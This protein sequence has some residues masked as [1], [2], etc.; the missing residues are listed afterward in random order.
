MKTILNN[1]VFFG[2]ETEAMVL[3][4]TEEGEEKDGASIAKK[5]SP[6]TL[7]TTQG[8]ERTT[9]YAV[10]KCT[11]IVLPMQKLVETNGAWYAYG[12]GC[13]SGFVQEKS[14][15]YCCASCPYVESVSHFL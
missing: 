8:A 2:N 14:V 10:T 4:E 5:L 7:V 11:I 13:L 15:A 3:A 6:R 12:S 1:D 9:V